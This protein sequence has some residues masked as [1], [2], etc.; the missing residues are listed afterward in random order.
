MLRGDLGESFRDGRPVLVLLGLLA[1]GKVGAWSKT[2]SVS[3]FA[4]YEVRPAR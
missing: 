4:E 2:D 1:S 3:Q